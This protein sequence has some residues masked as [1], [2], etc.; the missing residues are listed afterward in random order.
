MTEL[1]TCLGVGKGTWKYVKDL[2]NAEEWEKVFIITNPFGAE[3][4]LLEGKTINFI[5]IDDNSDSFR[6]VNSI[7]KQL[8][9][10]LSGPEVAVNFV[11]GDGKEHMAMISG[12]LKSGLGIRLVCLKNNK[13]EEL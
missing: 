12:I 4:F 2:I 3:K 11:S 9:D 10:N 1:V 5:I 13:I 8:K 6:L 7:Q